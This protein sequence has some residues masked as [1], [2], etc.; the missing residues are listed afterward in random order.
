LQRLIGIPRNAAIALT[1]K[2]DQATTS[3]QDA[4]AVL[5]FIVDDDD[6]MR[7]AIRRLLSTGG[8][9]AET[10]ASGVEF[11]SCASLDRGSCVILDVRMPG[12]NGLEVQ[13]ALKQRRIELPVIF[14]TGSSDIPIAVAAMREGATDFIEKPFDNEDL[15][16]RVRQA[17]ARHRH[18]RRESSQRDEAQRRL[19]TLTARERSV[20]ELVVAG[21][22]NKEIARNLG[23]SYRTI[24]IHRRHVMEKMG[25][26]TLADLVRLRLLES[27]RAE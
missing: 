16:G 14:L 25:V 17:V 19:A 8:L 10:Y 15:L 27:D 20:M 3:T 5:V 11:L 23:A 4:A 22:T 7:A 24:E 13:A 1:M 2:S 18:Q 26:S 12:M 21:Q 6:L 9:P